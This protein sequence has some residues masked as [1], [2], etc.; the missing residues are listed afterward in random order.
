MRAFLTQVRWN[1]FLLSFV[2]PCWLKAGLLLLEGRECGRK[3]TGC[4]G[5]RPG[6]GFACENTEVLC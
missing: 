6:S 5:R 3:T 1:F 2:S 4:G